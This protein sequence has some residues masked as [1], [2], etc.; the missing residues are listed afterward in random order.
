MAAIVTPEDILP[1]I[2]IGATK[3]EA[4]IK[5][6]EAMAALAAPCIREEAF[7]TDPDRVEQ[8]KTIIIGAILRW[9]ESGTGAKIVQTAGPF[10]TTLDNTQRRG[11]YWPSEITQL[12]DICAQYK[13]AGKQTAFSIDTAPGYQ[14][15]GIHAPWCSVY[16]GLNGYL[17]PP[18]LAT[19]SCGSDLNN[20]EGP[21]YEDPQ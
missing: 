18:Y 3:L 14:V 15:A 4:M 10:Q 19:C 8:L 11:M 16:F 9:E 21:I 7:S 20:Y 5:G 13:N 2:V 17:R 1:F 12:R 6:A